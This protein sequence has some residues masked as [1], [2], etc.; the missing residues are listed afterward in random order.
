MADQI[1][2]RTESKWIFEPNRTVQLGYFD[3][4][5]GIKT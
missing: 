4:R 3:F 2:E 1:V 5:L